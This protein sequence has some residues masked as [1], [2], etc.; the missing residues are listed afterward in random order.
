MA[1]SAEDVKKLRVVSGAGIMDCK[2]ALKETDGDVDKA[3][4]ILRKKG[5]AKA[6]KKA[7]RDTKDGI[8]ESYIHPGSKLGVLL[9]VNCETD[10]VAKTDNFKQFV[11]DIAM[12]IAAANPMVVRREELPQD[13]ID[14][15]MDIY[16]AQAENEKK[17]PHIAEKIAAGRMEKFYQ[18]VVLMEQ[19]FVKDPNKNI[20]QLLKETIGNIG[21]NVSVNRFARFQLGE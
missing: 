8:I 3:V 6:D 16:K 4:E 2:N 11:H 9:E 1:I 12:Q 5:I 13:V 18:E 21:E 10:F 19:S 14:K 20:E 17:P 15:E 7:G